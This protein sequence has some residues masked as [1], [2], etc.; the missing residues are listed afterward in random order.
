L[1]DGVVVGNADVERVLDDE[2]GDA[3][4]TRG[5][6]ERTRV[7]EDIRLFDLGNDI[8]V[9][10]AALDRGGAAWGGDLRQRRGERGDDGRGVTS[11]DLEHESNDGELRVVGNTLVHHVHLQRE[12]FAQHVVLGW[13]VHVE[14]DEL[15]VGVANLGGAVGYDF[16]GRAQVLKFDL[17]D[18]RNRELGLSGSKRDGSIFG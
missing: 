15:E 4:G 8:G 18:F 3:L 5:S 2:E 16:D 13:G 6:G 12:V 9:V 1:L 14:L 10:D 17:V 11:C 7:L